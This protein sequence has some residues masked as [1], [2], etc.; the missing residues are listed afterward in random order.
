[1][2]KHNVVEKRPVRAKV[3]SVFSDQKT[4]KVD[5]ERIVVSGMYG[6]RLHRTTTLLVDAG[7]VA[8]IQVGKFVHI[9]PCR[10]LSKR[11]AWKVIS[12]SSM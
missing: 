8:D 4:L 11:K 7:S 10:K 6:K 2:T 1:M 3:V 12:V 5:I 9:S